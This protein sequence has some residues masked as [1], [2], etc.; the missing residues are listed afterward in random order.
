MTAGFTPPGSPDRLERTINTARI[1]MFALASSAFMLIVVGTIIV[2]QGAIRDDGAGLRIPLVAV[3]FGALIG[4]VLVRRL[5]L[6]GVRLHQVYVAKGGPAVV[7]QLFGTTIVSA[8]L[9]EAVGLIG[10]VL[11]VLTGDTYTMYA[12]CAASVVAILFCLPRAN[13]WRE[14]Y[15][16]IIARGPAGSPL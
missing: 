8:A 6:S 12:L 14:L 10:F 2:Q 5:G 4:S 9:G 16:S 7:D 1:V 11:G 13:G 15:Q 3:A